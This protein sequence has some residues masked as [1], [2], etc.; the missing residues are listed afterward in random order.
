MGHKSGRKTIMTRVMPEGHKSGIEFMPEISY[1]L[2]TDSL[3]CNNLF[4]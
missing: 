4:Y 1:S 3:I 2:P